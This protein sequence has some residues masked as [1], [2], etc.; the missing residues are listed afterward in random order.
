MFILKDTKAMPLKTSQHSGYTSNG[1]QTDKEPNTKQKN[2]A[3]SCLK[4]LE[5]IQSL[6]I[7]SACVAAL[8]SDR[9]QRSPA[10]V[11][12]SVGSLHAVKL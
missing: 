11:A 12:F 5:S 3:K 10:R 4:Q 7:L 2:P 1:K 9:M 6:F 8:L